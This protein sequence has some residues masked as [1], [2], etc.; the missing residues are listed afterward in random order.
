MEFLLEPEVKLAAQQWSDQAEVPK[1]IGSIPAP[2]A[3]SDD[4]IVR[5]LVL[6]FHIC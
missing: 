3:A 2:S 5:L 4:T 6:H 1:S